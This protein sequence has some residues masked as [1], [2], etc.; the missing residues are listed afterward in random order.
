MKSK[1]E[2]KKWLLENC[3]DPLG[4]LCLSHLDFSDF[5]GDIYINNMK[6][7][8]RLIQNS[9]EVGDDLFQNRQKV[10][11]DLC[12]SD[13]K[14]NG[15]LH[16][17]NQIVTEYLSQSS[18]KVGEHLYQHNQKVEGNL[19]QNWQEVKGDIIVNDNKFGGSFITQNLKDDEKYEIIGSFTYIVKKEKELT[20]EEIENL[21]GYEIKIV[22][23]KRNEK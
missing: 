6:V 12:Q 21:L 8:K 7:K 3:V 5:N 23:E 16:Q 14:V 11:G 17:D 13:N 15:N 10:K 4:D 2:I 22:E 18:Q 1:K 20:K 9:Q 19:Y